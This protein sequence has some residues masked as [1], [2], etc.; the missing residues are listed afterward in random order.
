MHRGL[1]RCRP[2]TIGD[3]VWIGGRAIIHPGVTIGDHSIV[4][5]GAVVMSDVPGARSRGRKSRACGDECRTACERGWPPRHP[6]P[7]RRE[8]SR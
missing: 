1:T 3:N 5:A 6:F 7:H 4:S 2:I 8:E